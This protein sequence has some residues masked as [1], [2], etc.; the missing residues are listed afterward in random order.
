MTSDIQ[1]AEI[2]RLFEAAAIESGEYELSTHESGY[3]LSVPTQ[4]AW[5]G[6]LLAVRH[7]SEWASHE[8]N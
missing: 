1:E 4:Y 7:Q 2:R 8:N 3:Y 6:F 5:R